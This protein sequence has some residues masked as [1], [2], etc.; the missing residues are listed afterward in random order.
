M[1][2][3]PVFIGFPGYFSKGKTGQKRGMGSK[4]HY[5]RGLRQTRKTPE[6]R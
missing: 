5:I 1:P 6:I 3:T 4:G 2:E